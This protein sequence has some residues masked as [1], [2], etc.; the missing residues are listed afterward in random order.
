MLS[1][2]EMLIRALLVV[3]VAFLQI[4]VMNVLLQRVVMADLVHTPALDHRRRPALDAAFHTASRCTI[5][6]AS[7]HGPP[8]KFEF[9]AIE[10][11][12]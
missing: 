10:N 11:M 2:K 4:Y 12:H 1:F 3:I 9:G 8:L 6:S 5:L 7:Y